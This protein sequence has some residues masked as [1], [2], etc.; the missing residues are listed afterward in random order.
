MPEH[1]PEVTIP[2]WLLREAEA[3]RRIGAQPS[4]CTTAQI[5]ALLRTWNYS[6]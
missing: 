1:R 2:E 5:V 6:Y 3:L 4:P